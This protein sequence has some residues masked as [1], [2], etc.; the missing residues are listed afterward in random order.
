MFMMFESVTFEKQK[1]YITNI[2]ILVII[3]FVL[4]SE[5]KKSVFHWLHNQYINIY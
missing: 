3:S 1:E 5:T 2:Q 4:A